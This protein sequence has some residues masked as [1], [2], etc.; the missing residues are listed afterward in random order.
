M[1]SKIVD[2]FSQEN[3]NEDQ[4]CNVFDI[5]LTPYQNEDNG[6]EIENLLA[7]V[8]Y[9]LEQLST[10]AKM[11]DIVNSKESIS[12]DSVNM[13]N[14][15]LESFSI[16]PINS[17]INTES[18]NEIASKSIALENIGEFFSAIWNAIKATLA[19]IWEFINDL[20]GTKTKHRLVSYSENSKKIADKLKTKDQKTV[21]VF[22]SHGLSYLGD[23]ID[24]SM[25]EKN[26]ELTLKNHKILLDL[27]KNLE[28]ISL[29]GVGF[30]HEY[31]NLLNKVD[32]NTDIANSVT[33][34][35]EKETNVIDTKLNKKIAGELPKAETSLTH[36]KPEYENKDQ[37][38]MYKLDGFI[39]GDVYVISKHKDV[40]PPYP[41]MTKNKM[42]VSDN[43]KPNITISNS[44]LVS[45]IAV[46]NK[47]A[48][49]YNS[50][51]S[52]ADNIV[53]KIKN[54][55]K[56]S[57]K[58]CDQFVELLNKTGPKHDVSTTTL[59]SVLLS[60]TDFINFNTR[61]TYQIM[62]CMSEY[63]S[64]CVSHQQTIITAEHKLS[65]STVDV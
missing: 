63:G 36:N 4:R 54:V 35:I 42:P 62:Q 65:K 47:A 53:S 28:D 21:A 46:A 12:L 64:V 1:K 45:Y 57:I 11:H 2:T 9:G 33:E 25:L 34:I 20:L 13:I 31:T 38:F 23:K 27:L 30:I 14:I 6:T 43:T 19:K 10:L 39:R 17:K 48:D 8:D 52:S 3:I 50:I 61:F 40:V 49:E 22:Y 56:D 29:S 7:G 41:S 16:K 15:T 37:S 32:N 55:C 51:N 18:F 26:L 44:S 59:R 24:A 58:S 5:G 60:I